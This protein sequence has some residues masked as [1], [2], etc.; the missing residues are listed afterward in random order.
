MIMGI[1]HMIKYI[2]VDSF[3]PTNSIK[4]N[5][6]LGDYISNFCEILLP[7]DRDQ[8]KYNPHMDGNFS[9]NE[10]LFS[11]FEFRLNLYA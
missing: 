6:K 3:K 11:K 8:F 1:P 5:S 2:R 10:N 9:K 7:Y 4:P